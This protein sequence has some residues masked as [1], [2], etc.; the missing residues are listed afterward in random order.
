MSV[1]PSSDPC[2]HRLLFGEEPR[3]GSLA[4]RLVV[5]RLRDAV[6]ADAERTAEAVDELR[7][8]FGANSFASPDLSA[9]PGRG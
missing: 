7:R 9:Y 8:F 1:P 2:W 3:F 6:S 5:T 4:T